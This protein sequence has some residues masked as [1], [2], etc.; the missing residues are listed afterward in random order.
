MLAH[1][2]PEPGRS[3]MAW[4]R[5]LILLGLALCLVCCSAGGDRGEETPLTQQLD[6]EA[7][8]NVVE[9][10]RQALAAE[11]ID[12][13]QRVLQ[14]PTT[15]VQET[16]RDSLQVRNQV[17]DAVFTDAQAFREDM[18]LALQA[19]TFTD[20]G[21][22]EQAV[23]VADDRRSVTFQ[24]VESVLDPTTMAQQTRVYRTTFRLVREERED[25][26]VTFRVAAV[27]RQGPLLRVT[28]PGRV[29][30]SVPTRVDVS[31]GSTGMFAIDKVDMEFP[32]AGDTRDP[33]D[34]PD[35]PIAPIGL[36][37]DETET[38]FRGILTPPNAER[39]GIRTLCVHVATRGGETLL[40]RHWYRLRAP[41]EGVVQRVQP[42]G[43]PL[44]RYFAVAVA[45]DG[46]SIWFGGEAEGMGAAGT[47]VQLDP[48][49]QRLDHFSLLI[50]NVR[51][52]TV[53]RF[54]D[55]LFD[56]LGHIHFPF[57]LQTTSGG[58]VGNGD[59]VHDPA[60]PT[61][62]GTLLFCQTV[63]AF[64]TNY[65]FREPAPRTGESR[66]SASVRA[67]AAPDG[68][69]WLF[70]SGGGVARVADNFRDGQ[71]PED[72]VEVR[73]DPV[74]SREN[75]EL[76]SNLVTAMAAGRDGT[77]WFGTVVGLS[78]LRDGQF[79]SLR[80]DPDRS[81]QR[82][83]PTLEA[84]IREATEQEFAT[85][86][87]DEN[88]IL[89][90]EIFF[91][92]LAEAIFASRPLTAAM[93]GDVSFEEIFGGPLLKEDLIFSVVEDTRGRLWLGTLGG[94]LR[95]LEGDVQTRHLT[96][97][98]GLGS[99]II[100]ALAAGAEGTVRAATDEGVSRVRDE[101]GDVVITN[102]SALDNL[103]GPVRDVAVDPAGSVWL[104]TDAGLFRIPSQGRQ[105][106][107]VV[108]DA[109][110]HPVVGADVT[111]MQ[112]TGA[113]NT[114]PIRETPFRAATDDVGHFALPDLLPAFHPIRVRGA[115]AIGGPFT[116]AFREVD[117]AAEDRH[118]ER[119]VVARREPIVPIDPSQ[120]QDLAFP[121]VPGARLVIEPQGVMFPDDT[122]PAVGLTLLPPD[123]PPFPRPPGDGLIAVAAAELQPDRL[124]FIQPVEVMLPTQRLLP[125]DEGL[126][127]LTCLDKQIL[128]NQLVDFNGQVSAD[129]MTIAGS[130][131]RRL[132]ATCESVVFW[133]IENTLSD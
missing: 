77:L 82:A 126:V 25:G 20:L 12:T 30:A 62:S 6:L 55:L 26:A 31:A 95:R 35:D 129:R 44:M 7:I 83:I 131:T 84:S 90:L 122:V 100:L 14:Q 132:P 96:R 80:F 48:D 28:M 106:D 38:R 11:D 113:G 4:W 78:R 60:H 89:T 114:G 69:I 33:V 79:S 9:I 19:F 29:F 46:D 67:I 86:E 50:P 91:Q 72:A 18:T 81:L 104:A 93:I 23:E 45:P 41:G 42:A 105:I 2:L 120:Q 124:E 59:I 56:Q 73:Y 21:I 123:S 8:V 118:Q 108:Q 121:N 37:S 47:V 64:D 112:R 125:A 49:G 39:S 92:E 111:V 66:P 70:G 102:F 57:L 98:D 74:F 24:E 17:E 130:V 87:A 16:E 133:T 116:E 115:F 34:C 51:I 75:S 5:M 40:I 53:G 3:G 61:R 43:I 65:P 101:N 63:N 27:R 52:D 107:G 58:V 71:C 127:I 117:T 94:G 54:V 85:S 22:P 99:N 119:I 76:L 15:R 103:Q 97:R 32:E 128:Q 110:G 109:M 36:Q 13:L 10:Y 88:R 68:D 1:V